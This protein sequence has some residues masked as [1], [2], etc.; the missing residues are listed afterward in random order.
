[1]KKDKLL[2][3]LLMIL[4]STFPVNSLKV[5]DERSFKE[6]IEK[7]VRKIL[8][9]SDT[10][11]VEF[12]FPELNTYNLVSGYIPKIRIS[13]SDV[14]LN[15]LWTDKIY[16]E[17]SNVKLDTEILQTEKRL[18]ADPRMKICLYAQ[19]SEEAINDLLY[20]KRKKIKVKDP[21]AS[22]KNGYLIL[23]G[24]V[25]TMFLSSYIE[26]R[27]NFYIEDEKKI[28]FH[29]DYI[30][31]NKIKV[32]KFLLVRIIN[33]INPVLDMNELDFDIILKDIIL[34]DKKMIITSFPKGFSGDEL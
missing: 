5:P 7:S 34:K 3:F 15:D 17:F 13:T 19:I 9:L 23:R 29:S 11:E 20:K 25:R 4:F 27:G 28:N 8:R 22:F 26:A 18:K 6:D 32:P 14:K 33:T 2:L 21:K 30:G 24:H 1:M 16:F 12:S 31:L 10:H